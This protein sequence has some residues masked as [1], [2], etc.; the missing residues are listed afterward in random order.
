MH[1]FVF[2]WEVESRIKTRMEVDLKQGVVSNQTPEDHGRS[3]MH[4]KIK[5][6]TTVNPPNHDPRQNTT[7]ANCQSC[8]NA[9]FA[10]IQACHA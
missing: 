10:H 6:L 3:S 2:I 4:D 7:V 1:D 5:S 9:T 8:W